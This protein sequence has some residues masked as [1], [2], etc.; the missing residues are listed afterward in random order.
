MRKSHTR[1]IADE[2]NVKSGQVEATIE[3]LERIVSDRG[4][5]G[6]LRAAAATGLSLLGAGRDVIL[7]ELRA[8]GSLGIRPELTLALGS[9]GGEG[10]EDCILSLLRDPKATAETLAA[11]AEA[12]GRAGSEKSLATL[13]GPLASDLARACAAR[14]LGRMAIAPGKLRLPE[15]TRDLNYRA[16]TPLLNGVLTRFR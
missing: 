4:M 12:L 14:A 2:I 7:R 5:N 13:T 8:R 10:A 9:I 1:I 3:L 11:V 15:L 6:T 16:M